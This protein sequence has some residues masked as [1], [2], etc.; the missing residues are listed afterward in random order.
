MGPK[1]SEPRRSKPGRPVLVTP[2]GTATTWRA[3]DE[4]GADSRVIGSPGLRLD[5][6]R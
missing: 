3:H 2:A 6:D 5:C 1:E 4:H